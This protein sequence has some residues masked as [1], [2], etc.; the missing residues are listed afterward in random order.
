MYNVFDCKVIKDVPVIGIFL[1]GRWR[2]PDF[3]QAIV[4]P[5]SGLRDEVFHTSCVVLEQRVHK[6]RKLGKRKFVCKV[7]NNLTDNLE[8]IDF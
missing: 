4:T 3:D 2:K 7:L 8:R 6:A 5:A 1:Q